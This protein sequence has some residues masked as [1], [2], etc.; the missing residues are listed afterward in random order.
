[1]PIIGS[2]KLET[3]AFVKS[4]LAGFRSWFDTCLRQGFCRQASPRAENHM[5]AA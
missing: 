1:M 2:Y 5:V 4:P 3:D